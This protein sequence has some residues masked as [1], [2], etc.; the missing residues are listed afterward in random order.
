MAI[1]KSSVRLIKVSKPFCPTTSLL[2]LSQNS[3]LDDLDSL[4]MISSY[5]V[6]DEFDEEFKIRILYNTVS[7]VEKFCEQFA[8][9]SSN[10]EIFAS[11]LKYLLLIPVKNYPLVV[12][13]SIENLIDLLKKLEEGR[14]LS[15]IVLAAAKPKAL[16]LYEPK[17]EE[18]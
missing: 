12:R 11:I 9:L 18:V 14:K 3:S 1:P 2:V 17:I 16:R 8:G 7:V 13:K 5:L 6:G 10:V 15:Y 4:K